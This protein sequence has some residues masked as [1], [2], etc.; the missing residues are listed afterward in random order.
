MQRGTLASLLIVSCQCLHML[1]QFV[2]VA[3]LSTAAT[4][5]MHAFIS[6]R[7]DY[8]NVLY[9]SIAEGLLSRLQSVQNAAACLV[10]IIKPVLRQLHCMA[11]G[12]WACYVQASDVG[13]PLACRSCTY[14]PTYHQPTCPTSVTSLHLC[15]LCAQLTP[16]SHT[17]WLRRSLFFRCRSQ[18]VEQSAAAA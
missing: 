18:F 5:A 9:C 10:I 17:Q 15:A 2:V 13:L 4:Q 8:C 11:T 3:I 14:R 16:S 12:S 1:Q 7:L 6:S